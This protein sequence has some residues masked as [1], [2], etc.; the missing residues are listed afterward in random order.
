MDI[1]QRWPKSVA[2]HTYSPAA[3]AVCAPGRGS[4]HGAACSPA[5][6]ATVISSCQAGWNSTS[7]IRFPNRSWVR[8]TGGFS[9]AR[10]PHS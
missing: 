9:L 10:R 3:R 5:P 2:P 1:G 4:A 7:S 8:S 6:T